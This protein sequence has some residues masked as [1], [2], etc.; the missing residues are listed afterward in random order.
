MNNPLEFLM[1]TEQKI[2]RE[3]LNKIKTGKVSDVLALED[4]SLGLKSKK[5][6]DNIIILL[7]EEIVKN[8]ELLNIVHYKNTDFFIKKA[9][10]KNPKIIEYL[11][12]NKLGSYRIDEYL[13]LA[14]KN[15]Y[16]I[17]SK[18]I[19]DNQYNVYSDRFFEIA[20]QNGYIPDFKEI[21]DRYGRIFSKEKFFLK[22]LEWGYKPSLQ[23]VEKYN[24]L[25]NS[26][27]IDVIFDNLNVSD[28]ELINSR[29]FDKNGEA[30]RKILAR[31]PDI[32]L[33]LYNSSE[34]YTQLWLEYIKGNYEFRSEHCD[35]IK[36]DPILFQYVV[37]KNPELCKYFT[38][39]TPNI[40]EV[41][42]AMGYKPT[43]RD[44]IKYE[45][46]NSSYPM[47]DLMIRDNPSLIKYVKKVSYYDNKDFLDAFDK[48]VEKAIE[49]GYDPDEKDLEANPSLANNY[50]F[51]KKIIIKNPEN[52][53]KVTFLTLN[54]EELLQIA[55]DNGFKGHIKRVVPNYQKTMDVPNDLYYTETN[56]IYELENGMSLSTILRYYG[57]GHELYDKKG[58]CGQKLYDYLLSN[59]YSEKDFYV[60]F[61]GN[62]EVMKM[63]IKNNPSIIAKINTDAFTREEIDEL[64]NIAL[65]NGYIPKMEDKVFGYGKDSLFRVLDTIPEYIENISFHLY[66]K[67]NIP[68]D[69]IIKLCEYVANKNPDFIP[70]ISWYGSNVWY[71]ASI[72]YELSERIIN[73]DPNLIVMC[74]VDDSVKFNKLCELAISKGFNPSNYLFSFKEG[75]YKK[76]RTSYAI[77]EKLVKD[78]PSNIWYS[79]ITNEE[80]IIKLLNII[81][82]SGKKLGM[83]AN[84]KELMDVFLPLDESLWIEFLH[85][86]EIEILRKAKK[87]YINNTKISNTLNTYFINS[88][89]A[90]YLTEQQMDIMTY[91]PKLQEKIV[92]V[93]I[94]P[95]IANILGELAKKYANSS[96]WIKLLITAINNAA[97]PTY[98]N[99]IRDLSTR[100]LTEEERKE[101]INL[102]VSDNH[103][104]IT[105][106]E[107][108]KNIKDIKNKYITNLLSI[109][110]LASLKSA[111]LEKVYGISITRAMYLVDVYGG[112]LDSESFKKLDKESQRMFSIIQNIRKIINTNDIDILKYYIE[113]VK[114]NFEIDSEFMI[115]Y[116]DKLKAIFTKEFNKSFTKPKEEDKVIS[117]TLEEE[118]LDI[119][120][121]A[122][123]NG[124]KDVRMMITS[125][126]AYTDMPEPDDYYSAWNVRNV[127]SNGVCCSYITESNLG[128]ARIKYLCFGFD[129]YEKGSLLT[130]APYDLSSYSGDED[131]DIK[132]YNKPKFLLPEDIPNETRHTHNETTW[133]RRSINDRNHYKKQPSYIVYFCDNFEDRLTDPE[134]KKQWESVKKACQNFRILDKNGEKSLPIIVIEREKIAKHQTEIINSELEEFKNTLNSSLIS[135]I[136]IRFENNYAGNR[137]YHP[138]IIEKYFP[139]SEKIDDSIIGKIIKV[140]EAKA[141]DNP[142]KAGECI[143]ALYNVIQ[144]EKEKYNKNIFGKGEMSFKYD[145]VMLKVN[146]LR[147]KYIISLDSPLVVMNRIT[148]NDHQY[149]K[150]EAP[151]LGSGE[152]QYGVEAINKALSRGE[153]GV[154]IGIIDSE[155]NEEGINA[156]LMIHGSRHIK[157]VVFYSGLVGSSVLNSKELDLVLQAAKYHDVGREKEVREEHALKSAIIANKKLDGKYSKEDIAIIKTLIEFHEVPRDHEKVDEIFVEIANKYGVDKSKLERTRV[158]AEVLKDADALDRTRFINSARINPNFLVFDVSKRLVKFSA[159]LQETYAID[160][161]NKF[162]HIEEI[163]FLLSIYTPQEI[164]KIISTNAKTKEELEAFISGW[165]E[166]EKQRI[167]EEYGRQ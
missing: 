101:F 142:T 70:N 41:A 64:V 46:L 155:I 75:Y 137:A 1:T 112:S 5:N 136:V 25:S 141:K 24:L 163:E 72:S 32:I 63:I 111:Y 68:D 134:A 49:Y 20:I 83:T 95:F 81:R 130:S 124:D 121:A 76:L 82:E 125:V 62:F 153:L 19:N 108:L 30:Q 129:D 84:N 73:V 67:P 89:F 11:I 144:E 56:I 47:V 96:E 27:L 105:S 15:G 86:E 94:N 140:I 99:L 146:E 150:S 164:R 158:M 55:I 61:L 2:Y 113:K 123:K 165:Y 16:K 139:V 100:E 120:L 60:L 45:S 66:S 59:G 40:N 34:R 92:E 159:M 31:N 91:Y 161:I 43:V 127:Q 17:D 107:D 8:P 50:L 58:K 156:K 36:N 93:S 4:F 44:F 133:E 39:N 135:D 3:L 152:G 74:Y 7:V 103:L 85:K 22:A 132:T 23:F 117:N 126:G 138:N 38:G 166:K 122:G 71:Y 53:N 13:E 162:G 79:Q 12:A 119:Y 128:T 35:R 29:A 114:P 77:M 33:E 149:Q 78:D 57:N 98:T 167:G 90:S 88:K 104:L 51:M 154:K 10:E 65:D 160:D 116:E 131:Y 14:I 54:K 151:Y 157:N 143:N 6:I 110:N 118:E 69:L 102:L 115:T 48:L 87:L 9:I 28:K 109:N 106:Y 18:F 26:N 148:G 21:E 37:M 147:R 80:D 97:T 52:I 145:E 42:I